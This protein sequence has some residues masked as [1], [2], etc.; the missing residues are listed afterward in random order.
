MRLS[1][2]LGLGRYVAN[3]FVGTDQEV[4]GEDEVVSDGRVDWV[5]ATRWLDAGA[6]HHH[7]VQVA[8]FV[9][10]AAGRSCRRG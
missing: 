6:E 1:I 7:Q 4:D 5:A 10:F 9:L 2:E 3:A 8:V